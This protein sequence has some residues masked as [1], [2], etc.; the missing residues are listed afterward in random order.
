MTEEGIRQGH[1]PK[2][3]PDRFSDIVAEFRDTFSDDEAAIWGRTDYR[4]LKCRGCGQVYYQ[5]AT[6][7]SEDHD[8]RR[9]H[10]TGDWEP[11]LP[12]KVMHWPVP[13]KRTEPEWA[14]TL[15]SSHRRLSDLLDDVY[16]CLN[17]DLPIPSAIA[18]R[19]TFDAASELL[20]V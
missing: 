12:E 19:T 13:I 8:Y 1:C 4:I 3:G 20:S 10:E 16:G 7:F 6:V 11:Y 5:S 14:I 9:N 18:A 2:C 15:H 17:A